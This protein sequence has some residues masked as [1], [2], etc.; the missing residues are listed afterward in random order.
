MQITERTTTK[1]ALSRTHLNED[2]I[3]EVLE[4]AR[5]TSARDWCVLLLAFNHGCRVSEL[6]GGAP[7]TKDRPAQLPLRLVDVESN[8]ITIRRLKGSLTT[9][10]AL[11]NHRG[12]PTISDKAA[13]DAYIKVRIDDGSGLFFTGQKG[14]LTRWTLE[15]MFRAYCVKVSAARVARG[16][17]AIPEDAHR[18]H[19]I[20]HSIATVLARGGK[21][22]MAVKHH[23]GHASISSTMIYCHPDSR[24][25][26]AFAQTTLAG[27]F[28]GARA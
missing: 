23:L 2:E 16:A 27:A 19:A 24:A 12:Q 18:F 21:D 17:Q 3:L 22:L 7:A 10:Q 25:T 13:I 6:A 20:K 1:T 11:I 9:R 28:S 5:A 15:K 4:M 26:A 14:P 8:A